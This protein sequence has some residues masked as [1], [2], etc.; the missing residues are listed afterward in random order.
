MLEGLGAA[1]VHGAEDV[2]AG[3]QC[4]ERDEGMG[5][6]PLSKAAQKPLLHG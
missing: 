2:H 3:G 5:Y 6:A 4:R 1:L